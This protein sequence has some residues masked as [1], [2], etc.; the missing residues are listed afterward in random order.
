MAWAV[1]AI[2]LIPENFVSLDLHFVSLLLESCCIF[3]RG[4][5]SWFRTQV[6]EVRNQRQSWVGSYK[7]VFLGST[8][9]SRTRE[10]IEQ[11]GDVSLE[12]TRGGGRHTVIC[13][14]KKEKKM[15]EGS[16]EWASA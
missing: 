13:L 8:L 12:V 4:K 2:S 6:V 5:D 1:T 9:L 11:L 7:F 10:L 16:Q 14:T 15:D 3:S